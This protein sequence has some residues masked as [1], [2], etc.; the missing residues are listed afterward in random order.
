MA[1]SD[2]EGTP[3]GVVFAATGARHRALAW[4]A[5]RSV[6]AHHPGLP[7]DL[8]TDEIVEHAADGAFDRV[9]PLDDPWRRAKIDAMARTRFERTLFLDADVIV[10]AP[11][12]ELFEVLDRFDIAAVHDQEPNSPHAANS[13][14]RP[15]PAAFPQYN[16]GVIAY[17]RSA[18][19]LD[20]MARWSRAVRA[21]DHARDQPAFRELLWDSD[22]RVATLPS[23]Y[24]FSQFADLALFRGDQI[25]P[26]ILHDHA[27]GAAE[28]GTSVGSEAEAVLSAMRGSDRF[29]ARDSGRTP[30]PPSRM[31]KRLLQAR[32]LLSRR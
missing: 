3:R 7:V 22:L 5:A 20:L 24:N 2:D 32:M 8:F 29:L 18:P 1:G 27:R 21:E 14:R 30:A 23:A 25:A 6:R 13:W 4:R 15:F 31:R 10:V 11:V 16:T 9:V 12:A 26:R 17:R 19:M 28:A